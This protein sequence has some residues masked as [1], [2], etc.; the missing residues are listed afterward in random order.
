MDSH[1]AAG[2]QISLLSDFFASSR[3]KGCPAFTRQDARTA[4]NPRIRILSKRRRIYAVLVRMLRV[5]TD[6]RIRRSAA[7]A[8][9]RVRCW[10]SVKKY[11][12]VFMKCST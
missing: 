6:Q 11:V 10:I 12:I 8:W 1:G 7:S 2:P 4:K 5:F 3:W 9:I